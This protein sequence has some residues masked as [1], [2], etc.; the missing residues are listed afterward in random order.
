MPSNPSWDLRWKPFR[1][2]CLALGL[3]GLASLASAQLPTGTILG[4]VRD[5]SGAVV[6]GTTLTATNIETGLSRTAF[7]GEDGAYRLAAL[8]VGRYEVRAMLEGFQSALRS[9]LTLTVGQEAVVNFTL[10]LGAVSQTVEV[11]AEAPLVNTTSASLGALVDAEAVADLPLNGR[12]YIDLTFL[13]AG[14]SKNE[15]MT[16]GGTFVGSWFSS[17][18]APL[19]SNSYML[20]GTV[21]AN[22][23][24]GSA[25][26]MANTTLG[27]EGI[28]EWRVITNTFSAEYGLTMGSQMTIVTKSGTNGFHGSLFEYL[29]NSAL[30]ARNFFDYRTPVTPGRL[31]PFKRNNYGG[32]LGGPLKRDKLFFFATYE[33]LRERLGITSVANTIPAECRQEPL[34]VNGTCR[35]D[36]DPTIAPIIKPLLALYPLPNLAGNRHTF[37]FTQPT[38][39]DYVQARV[40]WTI[41]SS[42]TAFG[43]FTEDDT[44]QVRPLG[45]PGFITD[46]YSKNQYVTLSETHVFSPNLLNT[47]RV[48]GSATKL[49]VT[50]PTD[51]AGP[52]YDFVTGKGLGVIN[53]AGI[54]EFGPRPS[55]PLIQNQKVFS[56]SNDLFYTRGAHSLKF[57]TLINRYQPEF[58]QGAGSTGQ[59]IFPT[60]TH[61]LRGTPSAYTGRAP[62]SILDS[63][64]RFSTLGFY[65]QDDW[66]VASTVTLN[67]G[68]RYEFLT[69]PVETNGHV[70]VI[71]NLRVDANPTCA[72]P[73]YCLQADDP[74]RLFENPSY[75]N[76]SPR[77]GVAW[78][79]TGDGKT[80]VRAGGAMLY[81]VATFGTAIIGLNWPYSSTNRASGNFTIPFVFPEG[82]GTRSAN[83]IDF[84]L[85]QPHSIQYNLSIERELPW[86]LAAT[87]SYAGTR[88]L[89]LY[90]R[91]EG[92]PLIPLGTPSLDANGNRVCRNLGIPTS[93]PSGDKCWLGTETRIN[94]NWAQSNLLVADSNSYYHGLQFQLRKRLTQGLQFQSSYTFSKAIDETQGIVDAENT[95]SHFAS[96]D[97]FNRL[98][99]RGPSSF[100]VRHNWSFNTI[101]R[102]PQLSSGGPLGA[103]VN[104]WWLG[105]ILRMR[106][107]YPFTPVL[108]DDRS[109]SA[110]LGGVAGLDR[111]DLIPGVK[112]SDISKGTSRGCDH[113]PA[114]TPVGTPELWF[115]PCA[116]TLPPEGFL[117]SAGRNILRGPGLVNLDVSVAKDSPLRLLGPGGRVE[118]RAEVFNV[119]N[120]ANFATP[121]VGVADTPSAAVVFAG[122]PDEFGPGGILIPQRRLTTVGKILKTATP[123]RQIQLSLRLLF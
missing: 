33:G 9:G 112:A 108:G 48:S 39:E 62:G 8:P 24:G 63:N 71:R 1:I 87:L 105:G 65:V 13:Q 82:P 114:G 73:R 98:R 6:P 107:G 20:D 117:G 54:G 40:D 28:Q 86:N 18:G 78:D 88:G 122:S 100:D 94:R 95:T 79:V 61:F 104:G 90:R 17:N 59:V 123:S 120:H 103:L 37:P 12:N 23:L 45:F 66:R 4:T 85:D 92:N 93:D 36:G 109:R 11:T 5:G 74:G 47:V 38:D 42:D 119:L 97:P 89:D 25:G 51:I 21:M 55:A 83:G 10:E 77:V 43:R 60:V 49:N 101:Y 29:R 58:T 68:L 113:I 30:D 80:A 41:S 32:S 116:F 53:I 31:P 99:D 34:P 118:F 76:F 57:G 69:D 115:D 16:S 64:W 7:A 72:D 91:T 3:V 75:R 56:W 50:S 15:N 46:R 14:I 106:S 67:L 26:S 111:P 52:A 35:F 70:S 102:L 22:V 110:V 19:R 2:A 27:I 121:E 84:N 96:T 81:D 44:T